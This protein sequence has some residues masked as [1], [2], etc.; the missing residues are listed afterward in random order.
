M[1]PPGTERRKDGKD[2]CE[3]CAAGSVNPFFESRCLE[4]EPGTFAPRA[5]MTECK[6][7][8]LRFAAPEVGAARCEKCGTA[9][10]GATLEVGGRSEQLSVLNRCV[11]RRSMCPVGTTAVQR[12]DGWVVS[13]NV[14]KCPEGT[15]RVARKSCASCSAEEE[16]FCLKC[17]TGERY[18]AVRNACVACKDNEVSA[19]GVATDC[20]RC[21]DAE[22]R[23][24]GRCMCASSMIGESPEVARGV[25]DGRCM[26]CPAGTF[27]VH[28]GSVCY[29]C[30]AGT[31]QGS[32]GQFRCEACGVGFFSA[33]EGSTKCEKCENGLTSI[34]RF[35]EG[36]AFM[37]YTRVQSVGS[38]NCV[39]AGGLKAD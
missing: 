9:L 8:A 24:R 10:V 23:V 6:E 39:K 4:C 31:A 35:S 38:A 25:V 17:S 7:C 29:P 36:S 12:S 30:V 26:V 22:V 33:K 2:G 32:A 5:G 14:D 21:G 13:C 27:G 15:F 37:S 16:V 11:S 20:Q 34:V 1:C 3:L 28:G 19:G 18:D